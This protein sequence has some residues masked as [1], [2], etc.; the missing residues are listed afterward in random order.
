MMWQLD[1]NQSHQNEFMIYQDINQHHNETSDNDINHLHSGSILDQGVH[2]DGDHPF[3]Q[4]Q[5][6]HEI[7][8]LVAGARRS[9][10]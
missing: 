2:V 8:D 7:Q 6:E 5:P 10:P 1:H 9:P 3:Y 4:N